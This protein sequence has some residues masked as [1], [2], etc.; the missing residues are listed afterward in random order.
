VTATC[1]IGSLLNF[2]GQSVF[3][4][5]N[6]TVLLATRSKFSTSRE[7]TE[8]VTYWTREAVQIVSQA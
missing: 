8:G 5:P 1:H 7:N 4:R 3:I 2:S 6:R